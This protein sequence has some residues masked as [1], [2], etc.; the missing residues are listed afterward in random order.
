MMLEI[1]E[2][3]RRLI[4]DA[5]RRGQVLVVSAPWRDYVWTG[6]LC[7]AW[8]RLG[9]EAAL[10]GCTR[11]GDGD[12]VYLRSDLLPELRRRRLRLEWHSVLGLWRGI[13]VRDLDPVPIMVEDAGLW[14]RVRL[15]GR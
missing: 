7:A 6:S 10:S 1:S 9:D 5:W 13:A 3:A 15:R 8:R 2:P 14:P 12:W 11:V 4:R